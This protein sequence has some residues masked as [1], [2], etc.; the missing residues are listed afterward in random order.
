MDIYQHYRKEE[1]SFIDSVL[2]WMEQVEKTFESKITDFLDPREQQ[3][4]EQLIGTS[5]EDLKLYK[6]GGSEFAERNRVVIAPFYDEVT[7]KSFQLSLLQASYNKKFISLEHRDIMG[8]FLSLGIKRKKLGDIFVEDGIIQIVMA[9]EIIPYVLTNLT[10]I[11]KAKIKLEEKPLS[12]IIKKE[13]RWINSDHT[14]TSLRLD[15]VLKAIYNI[16]RKEAAEYI[17]KRYV[18]VNFKVVDDRKFVLE[19]GDMLSLRGKGRSK[20]VNINGLTKKDKHK[21]STAIL[22]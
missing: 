7:D 18:K 9:D 6:H 15:A 14:V 17:T 21:I 11:K 1:Q 8:A 4:V 3:I 13:T 19:E 2:S 12:S 16:S 10:A 20:L 22:N 5:S